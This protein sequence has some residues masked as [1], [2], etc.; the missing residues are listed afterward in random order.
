MYDSA[1]LSLIKTLPAVGKKIVE[2]V[3]NISYCVFAT[4]YGDLYYYDYS[5]MTSEASI[6]HV[7][8]DGRPIQNLRLAKGQPFLTGMWHMDPLHYLLIWNLS[9]KT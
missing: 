6:L 2:M 5:N 9:T 7:G 3:S 4:E 1:T 8:R